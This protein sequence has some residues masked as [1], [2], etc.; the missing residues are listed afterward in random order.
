MTAFEHLDDTGV[1]S[2]VPTV[3]PAIS[4]FTSTPLDSV[5]FF[6]GTL[7]LVLLN[8]AGDASV[9]FDGFAFSSAATT[10]DYDVSFEVLKA[11]VPLRQDVLP[12]ESGR[13]VLTY[14]GPFRYFETHTVTQRYL[15]RGTSVAALDSLDGA[16]VVD[17]FTVPGG[18]ALA[19]PVFA[20]SRGGATSVD[21]SFSTFAPNVP[22]FSDLYDLRLELYNETRS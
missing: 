20:L 18:A 1:P 10:L 8:D 15:Y 5:S 11:G 6:P 21:V 16:A 12:I 7:R 3:A 19:S 9:V 13:S 14:T 17:T 22:V 4:L 2:G